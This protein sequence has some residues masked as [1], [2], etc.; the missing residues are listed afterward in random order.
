MKEILIV[1]CV[2][3]VCVRVC[4]CVCPDDYLSDPDGPDCLAPQHCKSK[5]SKK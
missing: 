2:V 5:H 3:F 1:W 4:T